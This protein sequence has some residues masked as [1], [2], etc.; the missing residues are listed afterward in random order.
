MTEELHG[1]SWIHETEQPTSISSIVC[2]DEES[3]ENL[4][5]WEHGMAGENTLSCCDGT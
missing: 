2:G 1:K 5:H 3:S 4:K